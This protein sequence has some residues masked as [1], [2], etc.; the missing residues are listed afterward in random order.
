MSLVILIVFNILLLKISNNVL[1]LIHL[2][3]C[4]RSNLFTNLDILFLILLVYVVLL[5]LQ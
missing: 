3:L 5:I 1:Q 2:V 4:V